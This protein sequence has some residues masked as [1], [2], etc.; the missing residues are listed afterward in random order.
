M[1]QILSQDEVDA[2]LKGLSDGEIETEQPVDPE[3]ENVQP[4]DLTSSRKI[5]RGKMPSLDIINENFTRLFRKTLSAMLRRIVA[6]N[7]LSV[8][9]RKYEDFLKTLPLP[10]SLHVF[11]MDPLKGEMLF[12]VES[13]LNFTLVDCLFGGSG[14]EEFKVEGRDF[15]PIENNLIK[16]VIK[17]ALSDLESAWKKILKVNTIYK[18]SEMNPQFAQIVGPSDVVVIINF[19]IE[20]DYTSGMITL[21]I[22]YSSLEPVRDKLQGGYQ[23]DK[24]DSDKEWMGRLKEELKLSYVDMSVKLGRSELTGREIINLKKGDVILLDQYYND[25]LSIFLGHNVK[26]RCQPGIYRGNCAVKI[27]E[28]LKHEEVR[29]NGSE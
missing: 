1:S 18:R 6:I 20:M 23:T 8:T 16:R 19:E 15:T 24:L 25:D 9:F 27:S 4:Y 13:K 28:I 14:R 29:D 11:K 17:G 10:S 12:I 2:L 5:V 21:C 26:F 22:P 7:T 3:L